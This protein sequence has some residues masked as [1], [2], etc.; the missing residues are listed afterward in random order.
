M[1]ARN[2]RV[3]VKLPVATVLASLVNT[4]DE[5][6]EGYKNQVKLDK[7]YEKACDV[8]RKKIIREAFRNFD[9]IKNRVENVRINER[10]D[11]TINIDLFFPKGVLSP[12]PKKEYKVVAEW[13]YKAQREE[14]ESLIRILSLTE[15]EYI[16]TSTYHSISKY[17]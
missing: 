1:M 16:N 4:L 7:E 12:E 13:E 8:W 10:Y 17:L 15:D 14:I 3:N 11:G 5:L 6:D 2:G 9:K